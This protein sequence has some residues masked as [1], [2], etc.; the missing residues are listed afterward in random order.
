VSCE[1]TAEA[2][3]EFGI[4]LYLATALLV[5][6]EIFDRTGQNLKLPED[7]CE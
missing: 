5:E 6:L 3:D 7:F 4:V 2:L 1:V